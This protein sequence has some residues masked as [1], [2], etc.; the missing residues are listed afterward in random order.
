MGRK[1][2]PVNDLFRVVERDGMKSKKAVSKYCLNE[3]ADNGSR[4]MD[5]MKK[6]I[7]VPDE[8]KFD[9]LQLQHRDLGQDPKQSRAKP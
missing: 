9:K 2:T 7:K 6:C 8:L 3:I 4:K 1:K 5:H